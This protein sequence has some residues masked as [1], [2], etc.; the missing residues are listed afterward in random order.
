[1][2]F[3]YEKTIEDTAYTIF[4]NFYKAKETELILS[5]DDVKDL[6]YILSLDYDISAST[7]EFDISSKIKNMIKKIPVLYLHLES[8]RTH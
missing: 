5:T 8:I 1:M 2:T 3:D 4:L 6:I 7:V